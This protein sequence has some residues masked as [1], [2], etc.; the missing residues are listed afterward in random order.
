MLHSFPTVCYI[1]KLL[2]DSSLLD[3]EDY[4]LPIRTI[5]FSSWRTS[6]S[7][8]W[9]VTVLI[10]DDSIVEDSEHLTLELVST[11]S[12]VTVERN[13]SLITISITEDPTDC[14]CGELRPNIALQFV[15][16]NRI[17]IEHADCS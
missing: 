13:Y 7:S 15:I 8:R 16:W 4:S 17:L 6:G 3:M 1:L 14:E 12:L 11:H 2:Y 5:T 9:C 10:V